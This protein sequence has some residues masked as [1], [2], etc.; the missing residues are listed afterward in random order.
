MEVAYY[1]AYLAFL[2]KTSCDTSRLQKP[3]GET[4]QRPSDDLVTRKLGS[5]AWH[6]DD[7]VT[8]EL[9]SFVGALQPPR[10]RDA[11]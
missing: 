5:F 6:T 4:V 11:D 3:L 9:G 1:V 2:I 7:L 10:R 8:N